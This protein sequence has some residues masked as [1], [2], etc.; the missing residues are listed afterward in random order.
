MTHW[1]AYAMPHW[2]VCHDSL[3]Y[4]CHDS[5]T[6]VCNDS[7]CHDSFTCICND[8]LICICHDSL[9]Y[10][11]HDS[12]TH[13][14]C[15]V[16]CSRYATAPATATHHAARQLHRATH[17]NIK[18]HTT[19]L[20]NTHPNIHVTCNRVSNRSTPH[21]TPPLHRIP[22]PSP[23]YYLSKRTHARTHTP[24][25][26]SLLHPVQIYRP[27]AVMKVILVM[28]KILGLGF[29]VWDFGFCSLLL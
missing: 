11:C 13:M 7:L 9:T 22:R 6:C 21:T 12:L 5:C 15:N 25:R 24:T 23:P 29:W 14:W 3:T 4:L 26:C 27:T 8:S 2:H 17:I 16:T 10:Q 1:H 18:L 19:W 28:L 20:V